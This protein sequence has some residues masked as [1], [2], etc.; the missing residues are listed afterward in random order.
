MQRGPRAPDRAPTWAFG[1]TIAIC[2]SSRMADAG[3]QGRCMNV[4]VFDLFKLGV[5]PSSSHTMGP[6]TAAGRFTAWLE[7]GGFL[8]RTRRIRTT[9]YASLALTGRGHAT[10]RAVILGLAGFEPRTLDP[11]AADAA[12]AEI[13]AS[14]RLRLRGRRQ[15]GFDETVDLVWEGRVRLPQHPNALKL[16]AF[17]LDGGLVAER[18]YFSV[19]GGFVRDEAEMGRNDP[20]GARSRWPGPAARW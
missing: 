13:R 17:D 3:V 8:D 20:G 16:A 1:E 12:L 18:L 2:G 11:D 14:G 9:L 15:I 10:D 6:M 19:G 5:G 4:S 7:D